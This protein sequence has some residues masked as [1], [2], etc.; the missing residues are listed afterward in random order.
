MKSSKKVINIL[1]VIGV[2]IAYNL[3]TFNIYNLFT[4]I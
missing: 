3:W 4:I 2:I 1:G